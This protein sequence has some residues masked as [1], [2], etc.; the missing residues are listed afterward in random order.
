MNDVLKLVK[1]TIAQLSHDR[2]R[3]DFDLGFAIDQAGDFDDRGGRADFAE[4]VA[5]DTGHLFPGVYVSDEHPRAD[6][7]LEFAAEGFDGR[8]DNR[9]RAGGLVANFSGVGAVGVDADAAGD[10]D[11][12]AAAD[13][14]AIAHDRLPLRAAGCT[15]A[16]EAVLDGDF[17]I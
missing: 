12:V 6:D 7:V 13:R 9:E 11:R 5:V 14:A 4:Y 8:L 2:V 3:F 10:G 17:D 16:A 1:K 15:F